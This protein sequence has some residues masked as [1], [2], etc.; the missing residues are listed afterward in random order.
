MT[1]NVLSKILESLSQDDVA[2]AETQINEWFDSI[3]VDQPVLEATEVEEAAQEVD[4]TEAVE[5]SSDAETEDNKEEIE[6][7]KTEECEDEKVEESVDPAFA[8]LVEQFKGFSVV[9]K[10]ANK[11][12]AQVGNADAVE[13]NADSPVPN[14]KA[15]ERV[16]GS[17]VEV[18]AE[19]HKGF[20]KEAAPKVV[21]AKVKN[22]APVAEPG[23]FSDKLDN[24]EGA[25]VG[26]AG[27]VDI[28]TVSPIGSKS[29]K[30]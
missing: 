26:N 4:E 21:D 9:D 29:R 13:V 15:S 20:D 11:E 6:E 3:T 24:Q 14:I 27:K 19:E 5:E 7:A 17:P 1:E 10:L 28:N 12:G 22:P 8:D 2:A 16:G 25:Q 30:S 23:E 18:H